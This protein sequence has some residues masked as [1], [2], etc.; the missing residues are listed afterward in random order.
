[1]KHSKKGITLKRCVE[2]CARQLNDIPSMIAKLEI[3]NAE[4]EIEKIDAILKATEYI[5]R[6]CGNIRS[7]VQECDEY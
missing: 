2:Y 3:D 1:M 7:Y 4:N 5:E 6:Q